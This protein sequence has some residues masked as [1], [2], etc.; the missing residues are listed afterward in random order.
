MASV[1]VT[2]AMLFG[3]FHPAYQATT[4]QT[5]SQDGWLLSVQTDQFTKTVRCELADRLGQ[6]SNFTV[7][8]HMLQLHAKPSLDTS[9]A[10]YR[11]DGGAPHPWHDLEARLVDT[12]AM[13][14]AERLDNA[15]EGTVLIPLSALKGAETL[16]I[17]PTPKTP[18][19]S[20][21]LGAIKKL[22]P[23]ANALGCQFESLSGGA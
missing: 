16:T 10:W 8:P 11:I 2:S 15:T 6:R 21:G 4:T 13:V 12:G 18:P 23:A 19:V 1:L 20:T 9:S 7:E 14:Q 5:Y 17:R 3:L 22:I